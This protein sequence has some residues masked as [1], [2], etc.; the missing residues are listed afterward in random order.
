[1]GE[2]SPR[3]PSGLAA[4]LN[5]ARSSLGRAGCSTPRLPFCVCP[6]VVRPDPQRGDHLRPLVAACSIIRATSLGAN[7]TRHG[8]WDHAFTGANRFRVEKMESGINQPILGGESDTMMENGF[9]IAACANDAPRRSHG[10]A[11]AAAAIT[12]A[13]PPAILENTSGAGS[14]NRQK[15]AASV[16]SAPPMSGPDSVGRKHEPVRRQRLRTRNVETSALTLGCGR[17][18]VRRRPRTNDRRAHGPRCR[19]RRRAARGGGDVLTGFQGNFD[20]GGTSSHPLQDR[21]DGAA[22]PTAS[23]KAPWDEDDRGA[24][25]DS[26]RGHRR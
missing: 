23:A 14:I 7:T 9:P 18:P 21:N 22:H 24:C 25:S 5:A 17:G 10:S 2:S 8:G 20:R 13:G 16:L 26:C 3:P 1:V 15:A 6:S 11:F 19:R 4:T 12:A